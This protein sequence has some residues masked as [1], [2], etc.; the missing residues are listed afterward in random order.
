VKTCRFLLI[1]ALLVSANTFA[2]KKKTPVPAIIAKARYV[3]I[4]PLGADSRVDWYNSMTVNPGDRAAADAIYAALQ[5]WHHY[6]YTL[7]PK[8]ADIVIAV[9]AGRRAEVNTG[10]RLPDANIHI[11]SSPN[12]RSPRGT[13]DANTG[14]RPGVGADVG[15]AE[16]TMAVFVGHD[17]DSS[18][19]WIREQRDGLQD[20]LPLFEAFK[21]DVEKTDQI[22]EKKP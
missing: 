14:I 13:T 7:N 3:A 6:Q 18:P 12:E 15:P 4:L 8:D 10:V 11:G 21:K 20:K 2:Q 9:R 17:T 19:L 22:L 1:A 16:D 5:K